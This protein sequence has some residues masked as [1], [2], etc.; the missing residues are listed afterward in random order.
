MSTPLMLPK[1]E[2]RF[3]TCVYCLKVFK[4]FAKVMV[5]CPHCRRRFAVNLLQVPAL[6]ETPKVIYLDKSEFVQDTTEVVE[7]PPSAPLVEG[8]NEITFLPEEKTPFSTEPLI[9]LEDISPLLE[10]DLVKGI[11]GNSGISTDSI[12]KMIE[13]INKIAIKRGWNAKIGGGSDNKDE[14]DLF[15]QIFE[16]AISGIQNYVAKKQKEHQLKDLG[17]SIAADN[18]TIKR[19]FENADKTR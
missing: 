11:L 8:L 19:E 7:M 12:K 10:S 1:N 5:K 6:S 15:M 4:S 13:T 14:S 18:I 16:L 2:R 9:D 17:D 3:I